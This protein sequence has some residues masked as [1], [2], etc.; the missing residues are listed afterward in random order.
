MKWFG[1]S[2]LCLMVVGFARPAAAQNTPKAEFSAGY[3]WFAAKSSGDESWEKFPKGWYAD[4]AG[5][6]SD[7]LSIVGQVTGNYKTVDD[8]D[9]QFKLKVHSFMG[10]VRGSSPGRVRGYGQVLLGGAQ[11]KASAAG[12]GDFSETD[13]AIQLG[14]GVNVIGSGGVGL[15]LGVDYLRIMASDSGDVL[16]GDDANGFRFNVGVVFGFGG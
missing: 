5:N 16:G 7:T 11:I 1:V 10:G 15:R 12:F 2:L 13:F 6:I 14:G 9:G 8:T 4:I 3:N